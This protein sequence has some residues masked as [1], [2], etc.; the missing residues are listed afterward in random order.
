MHGFSR[1]CAKHYVRL[2]RLVLR[3]DTDIES[4]NFV[5]LHTR[6]K[7]NVFRLICFLF[8]RFLAQLKAFYIVWRPFFL[9]TRIQIM[10][11]LKKLFSPAFYSDI[12]NVIFVQNQSLKPYSLKLCLGICQRLN[13]LLF[14]K[15]FSLKW[16][17]NF[18][19]WTA[20]KRRIGFSKN[21][22]TNWNIF[23]GIHT[24]KSQLV[25]STKFLCKLFNKKQR[26]I[27]S[28]VPFALLFTFF[29]YNLQYWRYIAGRNLCIKWYMSSSTDHKYMRLD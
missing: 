18:S 15:W 14:Y 28:T 23:L 9:P 12:W 1:Y 6:G 4:I 27:S 24:L 10:K 16:R 11:F 26:L 21:C 7:W 17:N 8:M 19:S 22:V 25:S 20:H 3:Q 13:D 2:E 29:A 5:L